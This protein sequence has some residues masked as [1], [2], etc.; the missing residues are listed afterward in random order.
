[1][2]ELIAAV[3]KVARQSAARPATHIN[4]AN[5][6]WVSVAAALALSLLGVYGIDMAMEADIGRGLA[7]GPVA[8]RQL[9]YLGVGLIAAAMIALPH[10]RLVAQF[11]WPAAVVVL[12]LLVFLLIPFVPAW[13]VTPRNGTRG[14][15]DLQVFDFQP[16]EVAKIAY[17]LVIAQYLRFRTSHRRFLGLVIPAAITFV[18]VALITLQP[19]LGTASLFFPTLM[20]MLVAAGARLRHMAIIVLVAALAAPASYPILKDHQKERVIG[21][22]RQIRGDKEGADGI[23]YQS[24][25]AQRLVG[26]GQIA[27]SSDPH[28]R[29]LVRYNYLPEGHNDMVFAVLT[30]RFGLVGA[31]AI[32]GLYLV[33]LAGAALVA[34]TCL[35]PI[36]R[37]IAVGL[38]AFVASQV[39][40]NVGMNIGLLPIIGITLPFVSYGGSSLV[41]VWLMTGLIFNIAMRRPLPPYRASFEYDE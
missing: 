29:A 31:L 7:L 20:A 5:M 18:P 17:V 38:A 21:L 15:I 12:G 4:L 9:V 10:Y 28:A 14:W 19:D 11:G 22:V 24:F 23:N 34:A 2:A 26:S 13:L 33:W 35:E 8:A 30:T 6:A 37:L 1:M 39:V 36:G 16:S 32:L 27:G 3:R 25:T 40:V 41:T